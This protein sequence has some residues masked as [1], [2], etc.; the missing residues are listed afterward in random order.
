VN[1]LP[2]TGNQTKAARPLFAACVASLIAVVAMQWLPVF[3]FFF[4][5]PLFAVYFVYGKKPFMFSVAFALIAG[6]ASSFIALL[7]HGSV[8]DSGMIWAMIAGSALF[9]LPLALVLLP[10]TIR[11]RYRV[12]A[13]GLACAILWAWVFLATPAGKELADYL[14]EMSSEFSTLLT[15]G[16]K[17][18]YEDNK[19]RA[20]MSPDALYSMVKHIMM[21]TMCPIFIVVY[22]LSAWIALALCRSFKRT[23]FPA[24]RAMSFYVEP[25]LFFPLVIG[26]SG[27]IVDHFAGNSVLATISWNLVL[28]SGLFF[29]FQGFGI[30]QS[31]LA[32]LGRKRKLPLF[33]I[34]LLLLPVII[35]NGWIVLCGLLLIAG[36]VELFVPIRARFENKDVADPT[37]GNGGDTK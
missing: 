33:V 14:K 10:D 23:K 36:V 32:F 7:L 9:L 30:L 19:Y 13:A 29:L 2:D 37:P 4:P 35:F 17:D 24:F 3:A 8:P 15:K 25:F 5:V 26:M 34:F 18:T 1:F 16:L 27:I 20:A 31:I 22:A 11:F 6:V 12:S 28:S 21:Y